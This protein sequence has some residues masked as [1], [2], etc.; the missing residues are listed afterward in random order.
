MVFTGSGTSDAQLAIKEMM[1]KMKLLEEDLKGA[2]LDAKIET[3]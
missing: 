2:A 1:Q 3:L